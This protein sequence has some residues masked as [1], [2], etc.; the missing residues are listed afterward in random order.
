M[1]TQLQQESLCMAD[2]PDVGHKTIYSWM[3]RLL[4]GTDFGSTQLTIM[5]PAA[6]PTCMA[7]F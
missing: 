6:A 7:M 5:L 4:T 3:L 2:Y 1:C